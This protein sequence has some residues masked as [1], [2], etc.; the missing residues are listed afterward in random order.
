MHILHRLSPKTSLYDLQ[1]P[2]Y[3]FLNWAPI[4]SKVEMGVA[5][6]GTCKFFKFRKNCYLPYF[7]DPIPISSMTHQVLEKKVDFGRYL[8][9]S[10]IYANIIL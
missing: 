7:Y 9:R 6:G 8:T 1:K 3:D 4:L 2:R 5:L 10:S